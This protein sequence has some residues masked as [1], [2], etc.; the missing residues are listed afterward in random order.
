MKKIFFLA[1][2][3]FSVSTSFAQMP[4]FQWA[5]QFIGMDVSAKSITLDNNGNVFV[6]GKT[7]STILPLSNPG[8]TAYFQN[9]KG[10]SYD[11][12]M[13]KFSNAGVLLWST[14]YGGSGVEYGFSIDTDALGNVF[15]TGTTD[16]PDLPVSNPSGGA[17]F[18]AVKGGGNDIFVL[19]FDNT[20]AP[21]WATYYGGSGGDYGY[22]LATD[23]NGN[24]FITGL[25]FGSAMPVLNALGGAYFQGTNAGGFDAVI[26]KFNNSGINISLIR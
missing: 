16:S 6:T 3:L 1:A 11:I 22:S 24:V 23:N 7:N 20:G 5:K 25:S 4:A 15:V 13:L 21:L 9:T 12:I 8:G 17:Y 14:Y 19:K 10:G 18:Q 26:L 2:T